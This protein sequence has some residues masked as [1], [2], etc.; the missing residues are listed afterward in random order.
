M[1][2]VTLGIVLALSIW[3]GIPTT[4]NAQSTHER[5]VL[6]GSDPKDS[7]A[8]LAIFFRLS[9]DPL[10]V[11]TVPSATAPEEL[12]AAFL[13]VH[14]MRATLRASDAVFAEK[15]ILRAD[16][17]RPNR[18]TALTPEERR[19]YAGYLDAIAQ[20]HHMD[21]AGVGSG[22]VVAVTMPN[23]PNSIP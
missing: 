15:T 7:T 8:R 12:A 16:V 9:A 5:L 11:L 6:L 20:A 23:W 2:K 10:M 14:R 13:M 1:Q 21:I 4:V 22:R 18:S 19:A 17:P 3:L